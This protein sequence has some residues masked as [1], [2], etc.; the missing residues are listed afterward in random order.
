MA[1]LVEGSA[2]S[3]IQP[4]VAFL[5]VSTLPLYRGE[6]RSDPQH[7]QRSRLCILLLVFLWVS[8]P[9]PFSTA[10]CP[11]TSSTQLAIRVLFFR[12]VA[13]PVGIY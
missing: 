5:Q 6:G 11:P 2:E 13:I 10:K 7:V 12:L 1:L 9:G 4:S 3:P 8:L